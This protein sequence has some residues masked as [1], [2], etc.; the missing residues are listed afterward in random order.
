MTRLG[1]KF[2]LSPALL[3]VLGLELAV[4]FSRTI[5]VE[6]VDFVVNRGEGCLLPPKADVVLEVAHDCCRVCE[7]LVELGDLG[8]KLRDP[9]LHLRDER[10]VLV[11]FAFNFGELGVSSS[12]DVAANEVRRADLSV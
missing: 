5:F 7:G 6:L 9:L 1:L 12:T 8:L 4:S 10:V 11:E 3:V 2:R